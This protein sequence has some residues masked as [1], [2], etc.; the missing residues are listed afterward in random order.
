MDVTLPVK[1]TD[2]QTHALAVLDAADERH[3]T[4]TRTNGGWRYVRKG[5][6]ER[7]PYR[8]PLRWIDPSTDNVRTDVLRR[9]VA[10][11][12]AE[13]SNSCRRFAL[14]EDGRRQRAVTCA[15]S[16]VSLHTVRLE[17]ALREAARLDEALE[18]A[19]RLL[20]DDQVARLERK[21]AKAKKAV[22]DTL[23]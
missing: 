3:R 16:A 4:A 6:Q 2:A 17:G 9:L 18:E 10:Y 22:V 21:A 12:L 13:A 19:R 11:G 1:L 8:E 15:A 5:R 14:S 7:A 20:P 23:T